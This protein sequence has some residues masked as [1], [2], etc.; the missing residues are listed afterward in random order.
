MTMN[1]LNSY[2]YRAASLTLRY[3]LNQKDY[4]QHSH[5]KIDSELKR[6]Q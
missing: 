4:K 6:L 3:Q 5:S 2:D 1:L